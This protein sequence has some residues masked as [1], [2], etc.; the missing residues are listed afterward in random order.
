MTTPALAARIIYVDADATGTSNGSSWADAYWCLQD[1]LAAAQYGDEIRVAQGIYNP[2]LRVVITPQGGLEVRSSGDRTETFQLIN[3]VSLKGGYAGFGE[4]NPDVRDIEAYATIL[5]GDLNG[6]DIPVANPSDLTDEPARAENSLHV[7]MCSWADETV[8]LD[9]FT[10]TAGNANRSTAP[11]KHGGGMYN[12]GGSPVLTNCTFSKNSATGRGGGISNDNFSSPTVINCTFSENSA[13]NGGGISNT[14]YSSPAVI[15]CIFDDN[16][17]ADNG[18]GM[19]NNQSNLTLT[20]C[21]FRGNSASNGGGMRNS[22]ST[23]TLTNC[24]FSENSAMAGGGM[25]NRYSS[26]NVI[27]CILWGDTPEE[28]KGGTPVVTY[29]DVQGGWPGA[30]NIDADPLFVDAANG[31]YHLQA[32]SPCIDAGNNSA[33]PAGVIVA[34]DGNSRTMNG[35]VDMGAYEGSKEVPSG[36]DF[37]TGDFSKFTW[38][39]SGDADWTITSWKKHSGD[40]SA[41]AGPI[42]DDEYTTLEI[43]LDCVS[44]DIS[45]HCKVHSES[46]CDYL[47][48]YID[49]RKQAE[50]SGLHDWQQVSFPVEAGTRKFEW[51]Y[52]KD[53]SIS[54]GDD[55]AWIDDI[56]FPIGLYL[57]PPPP[58]AGILSSIKKVFVIGHAH[59]DIGFTKP[60]AVVAENY[61]TMI[62]NQIAFART[63]QDYKWNIEETWQ[64]EQWLKRSTQQEIDELVDMVLAGQIGVMGGHSTL[65]SGRVGV[66]EMNRFLWNTRRYREGYGVV[67]DTVMHNDVPGVNWCYPQVLVKSGIKYLVCGLNLFIGGGFEQPYKSYIFYWEGPDGSRV[68]TWSAKDGYGEG[69]GEYGLPSFSSGPVNKSELTSALNELTSTGYPY[70][71]VMV[72]YAHDNAASSALYSAINDWNATE[73]TPKFILAAPREFFEYM[74]DKYGSV[75]PVESGNW[76]TRWDTHAIKEPQAQKIVKN[77]QD[78]VLAAEKMWA[79]ASV[80]GLGTYPHMEFDNAWDMMLTLDEHTGAGGG[81]RGYWTQAEVDENNEQQWGFALSCQ[82]LVTT[83][84]ESAVATLLGAM[85][86]SETD[87]IVVFNPLCWI[88]TDLVR[89]PVSETLFA[90]DFSLI[91]AVTFINVP[92]QKDSA[93]SEILFIAENIPSIGFKRFDIVHSAPPAPSTSLNVGSNSLGNSRFRIEI[94][95]KGYIS[96][97]YDKHCLREL[98]DTA[99]RFDFNR[100]I[101]A[102]SSEYFRGNSR[103]VPDPAPA[104]STAM[105][106]P[107]AVSLKITNSNHP[108]A[109]AEIV[110]YE[111]LDRIDIVNTVDRSKMERGTIEDN[112]VFY[113]F[114]F[115]FN[116]R[117][118]TAKIETAAGWLDP[119]IDS[120]PGSYKRSHVLQHCID[121]SEARYGVTLATPDVYVHSFNTFQNPRG[122]FPPSEPTVVSTFIRKSDECELKGGATGYVIAEPGSNPQWS[123]RYS[124]KPHVS[125]FNAVREARFG[126]EICTPLLAK[127]LPAVAGA[128]LTANS[129]SFFT[130]DAPS[131]VITS[132]KKANFGNGLIIKLQEIARNPS[133]EVVLSSD[134]FDRLYSAR[135]TTPLEED[136]RTPP[137]SGQDKT[138]LNL[139]P[140]SEF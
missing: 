125:A 67:I 46:R 113:G 28:I 111:G 42:S 110:L 96:S 56:V 33:I 69:F 133:T 71:A 35:V 112:S 134:Y 20:N 114:T 75:I 25:Y 77:A 38:G 91:D 73:Q 64:L 52:S 9:G 102:T 98:V 130:L 59:L 41:Q 17:A 60:P 6:D 65:R 131:V 2:D 55:T 94:D 11:D 44:G 50:W 87:S 108:V 12:E 45:F 122:T 51:T 14:N 18:G 57:P 92:Y 26:P 48:F 31:D 5:S 132:I 76:T 24:T 126:W 89:V 127:E 10:I 121:I 32:G 8:V 99:D 140:A 123:L 82:E 139:M 21:L 34:V 116:L 19:R 16:S 104:V 53:G 103:T 70:D 47:K 90:E 106:G 109:Q 4:P 128:T 137:Q 105:S 39:L 78:T 80:L 22:Q 29:S 138:M 40:Y 43:T 79:I 68:L 58:G 54:E 100:S 107:V 95:D 88:R 120:M 118:F 23:P 115:P 85:A 135:E 15:N 124:L 3:G 129:Q 62:D 27:N 101:V 86:L 74:V 119:G 83:T 61:K 30:G 1:A 93:T 136:I 36:E 84:Q 63:R 37:E 72:Q 66:E 49:G 97:I 13:K 117:E 7:V 81:G